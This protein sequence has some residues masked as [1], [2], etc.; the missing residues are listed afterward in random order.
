MEYHRAICV[1]LRNHAWSSTRRLLSFLLRD[2]S[3]RAEPPTGRD[4]TAVVRFL[5]SSAISERER[6]AREDLDTSSG[7]SWQKHKGPNRFLDTILSVQVELEESWASLWTWQLSLYRSYNK[8]TISLPFLA[9]LQVQSM[10][11]ELVSC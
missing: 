11:Q 2:T 3:Y 5:P 9:P 6:W 7:T 4:L 8:R 10:S 1:G